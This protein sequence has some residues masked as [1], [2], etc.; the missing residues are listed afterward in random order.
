MYTHYYVAVTLFNLAHDQE[1]LYYNL[2]VMKLQ[3]LLTSKA[4]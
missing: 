1:G 4:T 3:V 2:L